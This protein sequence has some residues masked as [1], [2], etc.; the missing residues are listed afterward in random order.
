MS[1]QK[2][3]IILGRVQRD[4]ATP[5]TGLTAA[6]FLDVHEAFKADVD[7]DFQTDNRGAGGFDAY[8]PTEGKYDPDIQLVF[9]LASLG[10]GTVPDLAR[11]FQCA[12][13]KQTAHDDYLR[14][15]P[16]NDI[17]NDHKAMTLWAYKG[18]PGHGGS[19]RERYGNQM[20]DVVISVEANKRAMVTFT[21]KGKYVAI[22]DRNTMPAIDAYRERVLIPAFINAT[23]QIMGDIYVPLKVEFNNNGP[24]VNHDN[25][26]S[27]FGGGETEISDR[28]ITFT[29]TVYKKSSLIPHRKMHTGDLGT[30]DLQWGAIHGT[31]DMR[32]IA[33]RCQITNVKDG[34]ANGIET[35]EISGVVI[36]NDF[37]LRI[38]NGA[39]SVSSVSVP[40]SS[41][42]SSSASASS[43]SSVSTSV[44][45]S[46][47]SQSLSS[48]S[49]SA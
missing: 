41:T 44:S 37:E 45:E 11:C 7:P 49:A 10:S 33:S 48:S 35:Y 1:V 4:P 12:G 3:D 24:V 22:P 15:A 32:T 14:F 47:S 42:S 40:S 19:V 18:N 17:A 6:D 21:G 38:Y 26:G 5:E 39:A 20:Y 16:S 13:W 29:A 2:L 23:Y 25:P 31:P 30:I 9:P 43:T 27:E 34:N 36:Q 28:A 8:Q 46:V